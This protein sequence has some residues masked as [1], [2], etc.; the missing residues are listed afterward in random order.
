MMLPVLK[1]QKAACLSKYAM[2]ARYCRLVD[3][4]KD[5]RHSADKFLQA[6]S[7]LIVTCGLDK[8]ESPVQPADYEELTRLIA[9]DSINY[10]APVTFSN[11]DIVR[12]L[13]Q[14][15]IRNV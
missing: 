2:M 3:D 11:E 4:R 13:E 9:T 5:D 12:V 10:S 1:Y 6:I 14:L 8:L 15:V 7:D